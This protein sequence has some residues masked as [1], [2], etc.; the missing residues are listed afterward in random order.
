METRQHGVMSGSE[1][2]HWKVIATVQV[3]HSAAL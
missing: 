1:E 3:K 2:T